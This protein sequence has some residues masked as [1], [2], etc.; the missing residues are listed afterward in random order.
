MCEAT[1]LS[2]LKSITIKKPSSTH[3][4]SFHLELK[5]C[6]KYRAIDQVSA[7]MIEPPKN[8]M[9]LFSWNRFAS[10]F[11]TDVVLLYLTCANTRNSPKSNH[12]WVSSIV[13]RSLMN[14]WNIVRS[15]SHMSACFNRNECVCLCMC[16]CAVW[17][18]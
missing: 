17:Y 9:C 5:A 15:R 13:S 12:F 6:V 3:S 4:L 10:H 14:S 8:L 7:L 1:F 18:V 11:S 16:S 2:L